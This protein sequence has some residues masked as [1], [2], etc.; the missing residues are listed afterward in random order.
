MAKAKL[1]LNR[2][3]CSPT[4]TAYLIGFGRSTVYALIKDGTIPSVRLDGRTRIRHMDLMAW[5]NGEAP[6]ARKRR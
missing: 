3:V 6:F 4:E 1:P 5:I 2:S